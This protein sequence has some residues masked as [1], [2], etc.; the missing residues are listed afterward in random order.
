MNRAN[1]IFLALV[2]VLIAI[3]ALLEL[4]PRCDPRENG[5][6]IGHMLVQ[7]CR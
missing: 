6:S 3:L 2:G 7:G 4:T 5:I 1:L